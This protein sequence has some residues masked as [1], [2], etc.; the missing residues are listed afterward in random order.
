[1]NSIVRQSVATRNAFRANTTAPQSLNA[2]QFAAA[3]NIAKQQKVKILN[4]F[5]IQDTLFHILSYVPI[6]QHIY[7]S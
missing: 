6:V 4:P 7:S 1:M 2:A 3:G 5:M